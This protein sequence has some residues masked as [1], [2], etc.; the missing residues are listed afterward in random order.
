MKS[1]WT[2]SEHM[3]VLEHCDLYCLVAVQ[4]WADTSNMPSDT[5][6]EDALQQSLADFKDGLTLDKLRECI[7]EV[8]R[9]GK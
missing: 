5:T 7:E 4:I 6:L 2:L 9:N 3:L 1:K 8:K